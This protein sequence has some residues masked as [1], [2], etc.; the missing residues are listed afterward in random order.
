ML[1]RC[2]A[3]GA[4]GGL[5]A[6]IARRGRRHRHRAGAGHGPRARGRAI[7]RWRC[8]WRSRPRWRR[9]CRP[10][11]RRRG[12]TRKAVGGRRRCHHRRWSVPIVAGALVGALLASRVDARVLA[13]GVRDRGA[14]CR[15]QDGAAA[16]PVV[17][18]ESVPG[19]PGGALIPGLIGAVSA[20]MG[21]GGGTLT[22][23]AMT[24]CGEPMHKAVGTG[25]GCSDCGSAC[26]PHWA[27]LRPAP[28]TRDAAVDVGPREPAR[29][30]VIAPDVVAR[31]AAGREARALARPAAPV[32]RLRP[33]PARSSPLRML[34]RAAR[35]TARRPARRGCS[36]SWMRA[37]PAP[38]FRSINAGTTGK[39]L[40]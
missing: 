32:G 9:S 28:R 5:L 30:P 21:I 22:V 15:A 4:V 20:M 39:A 40:P 3:A 31:G 24:L 29:L 33:V 6:G 35:L 11:F 34:Y 27:Y 7:R 36:A 17:L 8:T 16:R 19:G 23:P 18:R 26:R 14:A 25:G 13:G 1:A 10:R 37:R 2:S 12:R 38:F